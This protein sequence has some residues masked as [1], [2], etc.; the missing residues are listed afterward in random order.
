M[1]V[2][3]RS[4]SRNIEQKWVFR[5]FKWSTI[6]WEKKWIWSQLLRFLALCSFESKHPKVMQ[7]PCTGSPLT[8]SISTFMEYHCLCDPSLGPGPAAGSVACWGGELSQTYCSL[9]RATT[10]ACGCVTLSS[11][12]PFWNED[13]SRSSASFCMCICHLPT[14]VRGFSRKGTHRH[15]EHL[16]LHQEHA[17]WS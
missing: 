2:V 1:Y 17:C 8:C 10:G 15:T 3:L 11:G 7:R 4:Q 16:S 13:G 12:P 9:G 6:W 5:R 14:G